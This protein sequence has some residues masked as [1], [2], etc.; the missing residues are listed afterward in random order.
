[1]NIENFFSKINLKR[2]N[3]VENYNTFVQFYN[4]ELWQIENCSMTEKLFEHGFI[5]CYNLYIKVNGGKQEII[6]RLYETCDNDYVFGLGSFLLPIKN[7][8]V[9]FIKIMK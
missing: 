2:L 7:E 1:M 9:N 4:Q 5:K 8:N 6:C 3:D